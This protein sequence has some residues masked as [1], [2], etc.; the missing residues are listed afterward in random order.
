MNRQKLAAHQTQLLAMR[1]ALQAQ[2]SS[3][4]GG[5]GS[6]ADAAADHFGGTED[7]RAQ[8]NT[9]RELEF[10]ISDREAEELTAIDAALNRI[11]AG[12]YGE[13]VD[14]G[15]KIP[16]ARLDASPEVARCIP[17]QEKIEQQLSS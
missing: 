1:A 12:T 11:E 16:A 14:C 13:C 17:C 6:R 9:E 7:S 3:Q 5:A 15:V 8:S 10:A 2:I 4:R